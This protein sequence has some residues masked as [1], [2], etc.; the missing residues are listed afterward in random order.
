MKKVK[1]YYNNVFNN[2]KINGSASLGSADPFIFKHNGFY[3]LT[4]TRPKGLVLMKSFD[5]LKWENVN[6]NGIVGDDEYL[7]YAF[8]PELTYYNGYFYFVASPCG[9]GHHIYRSTSIE[10][11]FVHHLGNFEELID[12]SFFLDFD[13]KKYFLRASETGITIKRFKEHET[14]SD[15]SLFD[16]YYNFKD[17]V[18]GNWTEGPYLLK[19]YGYYYL[20]YTG[21]HFLSNA[22]RVDYASGKELK[23][24]S[25]KF[26]NTILLS[27]DEKFYGLGH[28]MTFLGPD[29]DSYYIAYHNMMPN[30]ERYLNISRLMFNKSGE[31]MVN[32]ARIE[33][34]LMFKRP[35][36]ETFINEEN[37]IS[38]ESF[39]NRCFSC[40]YNFIGEDVKLFVGYKDENNYQYFSLKSDRL[41]LID[42][43]NKEEKVNYSHRFNNVYDLKVFHCIRIQ[44]A[45]NE[46]TLYFDNM[47]IT[48]KA[49]V[50]INRGKIGFT[51]N[52]L[53]LAY[54][55]YSKNAYGSSDIEE[56]KSDCFYLDNCSRKNKKISTKFTIHEDGKYLICLEQNK[57][58]IINHLKI[59]GQIQKE[60]II[61]NHNNE[62]IGKVLL[63][64]GVHSFELDG[65]NCKNKIIKFIKFDD[66]K[67]LNQNN[68][69]TE[70]CVFG[71]YITLNDKIYFENDRNAIITDKKYFTYELQVKVDIVGYPIKNDTFVGLI[72]DSHHYSKS[73]EFENAYSLQGYLFVINAKNA[74][75]IDA[76]YAHSKILKKMALKEMKGVTLKIIKEKYQILFYINNVLVYEAL[77]NKYISGQ[78][79]IYNNHASGIFSDYYLKVL[80]EEI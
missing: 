37:F 80:K 15:F 13:E 69:I 21:T 39:D 79:G 73:N 51:N 2:K 65:I 71:R 14:T 35:L 20:T 26:K 12:G 45:T 27:T 67:D 6:D 3:Y 49:K 66:I 68:F 22:Y 62:I 60:N 78:C 34:N 4:C 16:E 58:C 1:T 72:A 46:M 8:A 17:S 38:E 24:E 47:E 56:I 64:K 11:P 55:A 57:S 54:I 10:G 40:E 52:K 48:Y 29:L 23:P 63:Q 70:S 28:S 77:T 41:E 76:N 44:Y 59:D 43:V 31:M 36:F 7:K 25:L 18:I 33:H 19:R 32:G 9:N 50:H 74:F 53:K 42:V 61:A 5:L 75:I 30:K